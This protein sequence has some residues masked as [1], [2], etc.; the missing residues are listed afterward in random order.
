MS[1]GLRILYLP[2]MQLP[3]VYAY[4]DVR[5]FLRDWWEARHRLDPSFSKSE[6]SR[7]LGLPN[8]RSY[9]TDIL[10]GKAISDLF[11]VRFAEVLQL[12][13]EESRYFRALVDLNQ[14]STPE[15][16]EVAFE[17]VVTLNRTPY[18][19][20]DPRDF[21]YYKHWWN[22]AVRAVL[23]IEDHAE[24]WTLLASR[25]QP[26]ITVRQARE[27]VELMAELGLVARDDRGFWKPRDVALSSG[28][29]LK[30][31]L[32]V[33][34]QIQQFD[35]ARR[36]IVTKFDS[37][38]E[39]ATSTLSLSGAGL[40]QVRSRFHQFRAEVRSIAVQDPD[41]ADRVYSLCTALF[42]LTKSE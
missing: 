25:I 5:A 39:V 1:D 2:G 33:Q 14:A 23:D 34:L 12:T 42:P 40:E 28:E 13:L 18:R 32:V 26:A 21:R 17:A 4:Q 6:M 19:K 22:G 35:L 20:L 3:N 24:D 15:E 7:R 38:K 31:E 29:D 30:D 9:F 16:R 36:A 11:V 27:S 10:A 37:A 41:P 8:T